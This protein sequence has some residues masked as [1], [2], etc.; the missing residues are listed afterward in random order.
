MK[1]VNT[2]FVAILVA[3]T[4]AATSALALGAGKQLADEL[5]LERAAQLALQA[6]PG[7]LLAVEREYERGRAV[8]E[9]E[10]E[11]A[12]GQVELM[13]DA[14]TA[15]F[16]AHRIDE[17]LEADDEHLESDEDDDEFSDWQFSEDNRLKR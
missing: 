6:Q 4:I 17:N 13:L 5:T 12:Q 16:V 2:K 15:Q 10:I 7:Q 14:H 3:S 8:F 9:V 1:K 11:T